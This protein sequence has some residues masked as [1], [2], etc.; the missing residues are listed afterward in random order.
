MCEGVFNVRADC[1]GDVKCVYGFKGAIDFYLR[2]KSLSI[3]IV[4]NCFLSISQ[5]D[6]L[7]LDDEEGDDDDD[8]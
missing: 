6:V 5:G 3:I 1:V 8:V 4:L 7:V 2:P